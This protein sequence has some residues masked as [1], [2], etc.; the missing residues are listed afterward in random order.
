MTATRDERFKPGRVYFERFGK[1][2]EIHENFIDTNNPLN[3][4]TE[5][6]LF[7]N[8]DYTYIQSSGDG[9]GNDNEDFR[10]NLGHTNNVEPPQ[11]TWVQI[12]DGMVIPFART[13]LAITTQGW[14]EKIYSGYKLAA[15]EDLGITT[16]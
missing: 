5:V 1:L 16:T 11:S 12:R 15:G 6:V 2:Y 10:R 14:S 3:H 8:Q 9:L 13:V 7:P 4:A